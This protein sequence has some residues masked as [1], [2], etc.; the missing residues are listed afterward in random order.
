MLAKK[1]IVLLI[2][3]CFAATLGL[4]SC[5]QQ[6]TASQQ[7]VTD[8]AS[9]VQAGMPPLQP[10]SD[11]DGRWEQQGEKGCYGCH[12]AGSLGNPML[13][14]AP[15][16]PENHYTGASSDSKEVDPGRLQCITCHPVG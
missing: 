10:A 14:S 1:G 4:A 6:K 12:G 13:T 5:A 9:L 7:T 2:A 16:M 8:N 11:H 3:V 15:A